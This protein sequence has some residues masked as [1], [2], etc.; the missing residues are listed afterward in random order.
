MYQRIAIKD[1]AREVSTFTQRI[2]TAMGF[3]LLFLAVLIGRLA[4][5]QIY[6]HEH[7]I[8]LSD[9]NRVSIVPELP[10]RGLIFDRNGRLLADNLP[11]FTLVIVPER[12]DDLDGVISELN[13]LINITEKDIERFKI[14]LKRSRRFKAIPLRYYLSDEEVARFAVNRHRYPGV[15][16]EARLLRHYPLGELGVHAVGY[17]GRVSEE[18]LRKPGGE[19]LQNID[20]VG[21]VGIESFYEDTLRGVEGL[22]RVEADAQ[23]RVLRVLDREPPKPGANLY[24]SLDIRLQ[25]IAES[26]LGE[27]KGAVVAIKPDT[28]DVLVFASRPGYDPNLFVTGIDATTY[29]GLQQSEGQPLFNRAL[30]GRYP[31]GSTLKPFVGLAALEQGIRSHDHTIFCPGWFTL[32]DG[33]RRYRDWKKQG[34]GMMD[35]AKAIEQSCDVYFYELGT[36]MGI[37]QMHDYLV[38]FGFNTK[39]GIDIHGESSGL[40]PSSTWKRGALGESWYLGET[41]IATIGQGYTLATP[42]Q[43]ALTTGTLAN[44]GVRMKAKMVDRMTDPVSGS[45][46]LVAPQQMGSVPVVSDE[47]WSLMIDSMRRV[48]H[49]IKGTARSLSRDIDYIMAGKTGTAQV[50]GVKEDEEYDAEKLA[51]KLRDHAL[52]IAFAPMDDPQIAVAVIV[53]NG[54]SG[55]AV[56]GPIARKIMDAYLTHTSHKGE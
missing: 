22:Q 43:L 29:K 6:S 50:F 3:I 5:L 16:I 51:K 13:T 55:G 20:Y 38:Q 41:L 11:A 47:N 26:A 14:Q 2:A 31:P 40:I 42:V 17:V 23:G 30:R 48:V 33:E 49:S 15:N 18:D 7:Y 4:Y 21:K 52:F 46:E 39:T 24:L 1:H 9:N 8:T 44:R 10:T 45:E 32:E 27:E 53:E 19:K 36:A 25:E 34:H 35:L 28:G 56:A 37:D 54:G 12:V